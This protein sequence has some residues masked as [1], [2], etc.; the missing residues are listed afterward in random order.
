MI[1]PHGKYFML[2][3]AVPVEAYDPTEGVMDET[4]AAM[5]PAE[6]RP[7]RRV[8]YESCSRRTTPYG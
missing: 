3:V 8:L 2:N 7:C 5:T 1:M 6:W 4:K